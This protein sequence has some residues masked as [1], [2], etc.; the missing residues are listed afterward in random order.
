MRWILAIFITFSYRLH[1]NPNQTETMGNSLKIVLLGDLNSGYG[2][3]PYEISVKQ[4][5]QSILSL[6]PDFVSGVDDYVAEQKTKDR[7]LPYHSMWEVFTNSILKP[8]N[9]HCIPFIPTPGNHDAS[10]LDRKQK[11]LI[12]IVLKFMD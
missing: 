9:D 3:T 5:V 10:A 12:F 2:S 11:I 7:N 4:A 6:S 1:A 8:I